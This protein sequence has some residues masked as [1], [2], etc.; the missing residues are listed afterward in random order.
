M[1]AGVAAAFTGDVLVSVAVGF[2]VAAGVAVVPDVE[3][4]TPHP[5]VLQLAF[6]AGC[7]G[8]MV[9]DTDMASDCRGHRA[10]AVDAARAEWA[11]R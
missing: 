1:A 5:S 10:P 3:T 8:S 6:S 4:R 7:F 9:V 2:A 11:V